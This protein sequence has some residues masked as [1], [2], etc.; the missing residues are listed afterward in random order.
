MKG[1]RHICFLCT[2]AC[3]SISTL[4][5]RHVS[6]RKVHLFQVP[7][8]CLYK[9]RD[10]QKRVADAEARASSRACPALPAV[11]L[12]RGDA[13]NLQ[14]QRRRLGSSW[15]LSGDHVQPRNVRAGLRGA[16]PR[17]PRVSGPS[18]RSSNQPATCQPLTAPGGGGLPAA[19]GLF[20][21]ARPGAH[22]SGRDSSLPPALG[23]PLR[24]RSPGRAA[25]PCRGAPP[26]P[27]ASTY[28][29]DSSQSLSPLP[30]WSVGRPGTGT[31]FC[32]MHGP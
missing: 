17:A 19:P 7:P 23:H 18:R 32:S 3:R 26:A 24:P 5:L 10:V 22:P 8:H 9:H 13:S 6:T 20:V 15:A 29:S 25:G 27:A 21:H 16:G 28:H 11:R 30:R 31:A 12:D 1:N 2:C 4:K 14:R